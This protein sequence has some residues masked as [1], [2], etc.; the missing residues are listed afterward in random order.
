MS[1]YD[2]LRGDKI[3]WYLLESFYKDAGLEIP[4][5]EELQKYYKIEE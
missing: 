5:K 2:F 3:N 1:D 4:N